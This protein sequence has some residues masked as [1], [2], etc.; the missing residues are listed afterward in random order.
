LI[1]GSFHIHVSTCA[2]G[3]PHA[4]R[5]G[6]VLDGSRLTLYRAPDAKP[7]ATLDPAAIET[8]IVSLAKRIRDT[9]Q[10]GETTLSV[11]GRLGQQ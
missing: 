9:R 3:C 5:P 7:L 6:I 1:D 2:K 8:G 10:P 11:L 4:G